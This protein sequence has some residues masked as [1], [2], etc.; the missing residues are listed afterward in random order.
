M[1]KNKLLRILM[2][3]EILFL[4]LFVIL[5]VTHLH[6]E[7]NAVTI[8]LD[9]WS[10]ILMLADGVFLFSSAAART[11]VKYKLHLIKYNAMLLTNCIII[12][13]FIVAASYFF[14]N[15]W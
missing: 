14:I 5:I 12:G 9:T 3:C 4:S 10:K 13:L 11:I 2:W 15:I 8:L 1:D 6:V 7:G